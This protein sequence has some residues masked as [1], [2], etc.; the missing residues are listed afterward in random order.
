MISLIL[1][2][3]GDAAASRVAAGLEGV[4]AQ[5]LASTRDGK[6]RTAVEIMR[7]GIITSKAIQENR[8]K[9]LAQIIEGRQG[10]MQSLDQHLVELHHAR[11]ISGTEAMRLAHNPEAVGEGLRTTI[12]A[13]PDADRPAS[14]VIDVLA[15]F[16]RVTRSFDSGRQRSCPLRSVR[17][18][19]TLTFAGHVDK[20]QTVFLLIKC[21]T[22][23]PVRDQRCCRSI[24]D[25]KA[26]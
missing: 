5:R 25:E 13:I 24:D 6:S 3:E 9:D 14:A 4:I 17:D 21:W 7:G 20:K 22:D 2:A 26:P 8:L 23:R 11:A 10:G 18:R 16:L 15:Q 12:S 1:P 19:V